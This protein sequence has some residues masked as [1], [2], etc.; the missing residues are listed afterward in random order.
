ML[1]VRETPMASNRSWCGKCQAVLDTERYRRVICCRIWWSWHPGK[2]VCAV[3]A[4]EDLARSL[5]AAVL[6]HTGRQEHS[7][8]ERIVQQLVRHPP[9]HRGVCHEQ[10]LHAYTRDGA[11][12]FPHHAP[13]LAI[14]HALLCG[15]HSTTLIVLTEHVRTVHCMTS[16]AGWHAVLTKHCAVLPRAA[17]DAERAE[18][19]GGACHEP[20]Q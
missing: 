9:A 1:N 19:A 10:C 11:V 20:V 8:L 6:A 14:A 3:Q 15:L 18:K 2:I 7:A 13:Q 4:R 17:S 12:G 16:I 5:T